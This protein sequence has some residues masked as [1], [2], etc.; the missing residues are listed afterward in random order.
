MDTFVLDLLISREKV[1]IYTTL[2]SPSKYENNDK[3]ILKYFQ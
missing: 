2:F 1:K 3:T